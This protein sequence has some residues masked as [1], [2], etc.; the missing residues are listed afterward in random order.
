QVIVRTEREQKTI[1]QPLAV[2][3]NPH[4]AF[5]VRC[6]RLFLLRRRL[7]RRSLFDGHGYAP[8]NRCSMA[9]RR[10]GSAPKYRACKDAVGSSMNRRC[11]ACLRWELMFFITE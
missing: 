5:Y 11:S 2:H 3:P 4:A 7:L 9:K 1:S 6:R 10:L 8:P